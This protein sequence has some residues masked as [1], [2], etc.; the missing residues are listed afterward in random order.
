MFKRVK[1]GTESHEW[2][3]TPVLQHLAQ[4][5]S[6]NYWS[7][8]SNIETIDAIRT[9]WDQVSG[10]ESSKVMDGDWI[11]SFR[12]DGNGDHGGCISSQSL[13]YQIS[14]NL[15]VW[16]NTNLF[17]CSYG[18]QR[19]KSR[20]WQTWFLLEA[21]ADNLFF[22]SFNISWLMYSLACDPITPISAFVVTLP[23]LLQ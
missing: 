13:M 11:T 18:G 17:P 10:W 3:L 23:F 12:K 5:L 7:K 19:L 20:C 9:S 22:I 4:W 6:R 8:F 21:P 14:T 16:D 2:V 1:C 15:V